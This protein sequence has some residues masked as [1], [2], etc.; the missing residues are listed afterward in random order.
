VVSSSV[1]FAES[2]T[3]ETWIG[4][5]LHVSPRL[6]GSLIALYWLLATKT[7]PGRPP[8][9]QRKRRRRHRPAELLQLLRAL[10]T[11]QTLLHV[12]T[13]VRGELAA[14]SVS[15]S[16]DGL[17]FTDLIRAFCIDMHPFRVVCADAVRFETLP[18]ESPINGS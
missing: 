9:R 14:L 4:P 7:S 1:P 18:P 3:S 8:I 16:P 10:D 11:Q 15:A 13:L 12:L 6:P 5:V 17:H 2:G